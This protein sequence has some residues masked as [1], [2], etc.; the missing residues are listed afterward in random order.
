MHTMAQRVVK[1]LGGPAMVAEMLGVSRIAVYKWMYPRAKGGTGGYIPA[2][3][4]LELMVTAKMMGIEL[5]KDDFFPLE[6]ND[7][8][9]I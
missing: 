7:A 5:T 2:R 3:R 9:E 4:Q 8:P 1:K 6:T